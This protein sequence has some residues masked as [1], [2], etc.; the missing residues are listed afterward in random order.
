MVLSLIL[1]TFIIAVVFAIGFAFGYK[2]GKD[3]GTMESYII[4]MDK[5]IELQKEKKNTI[6]NKRSRT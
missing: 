6:N 2:H 4:M 1:S 3:N 5:L